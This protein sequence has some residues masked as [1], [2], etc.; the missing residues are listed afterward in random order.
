MCVL[1]IIDKYCHFNGF[2]SGKHCKIA[3]WVPMTS[4]E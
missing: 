3:L 4:A 2:L 1:F